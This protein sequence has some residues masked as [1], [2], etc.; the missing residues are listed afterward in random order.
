MVTE[1]VRQNRL[2]RRKAARVELLLSDCDGVLTDGGVYYSERGEELKRFSVRD[3][4]GVA[5]LRN[6]ALVETGVL[7]GERSPSLL[8]RLEKLEIAEIHLG[9]FDKRAALQ[10]I[11]ERRRLRP[12]Q[13]AFIGD[14][15]N[16]LEV[17][18]SVGLSACPRDALPPVIRAVDYVCR[19]GG[20]QGAFREFAEVVIAG[21]T[22]G[23]GI[24]SS[25]TIKED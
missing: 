21:R 8:K 19:L 23:G 20:G 16:D 12:E 15:I 10:E 3:G 6:V 13:V 1:R 4:M 22:S 14:D 18:R 9:L 5:L 7:S 11:L 25:S 2:I 17:L 24:P